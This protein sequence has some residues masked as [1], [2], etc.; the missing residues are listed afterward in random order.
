MYDLKSTAADTDGPTDD[1]SVLFGADNQGAAT[2]K[3]YSFG[4]IKA[5]IKSFLTGHL[6]GETSNGNAAA[7]ELGEYIESEVLSG[8][9]VALTTNTAANVTSYTFPAGDY[10]IS[11]AV[12]FSPSGGAAPTFL[13]ATTNTASAALPTAPNKGAYNGLTLA[14]TANQAQV[15][16]FAPRRHSFAANTTVYLIAY[17]TFSAGAL[18]AYG[19]LKARRAR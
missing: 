14:F 17:G 19:I 6:P 7:G 4:G 13:A 10:E 8:A 3:P 1:N 18:S 5:W 2:P 15:M 11:G 16:S 9:A 12:V